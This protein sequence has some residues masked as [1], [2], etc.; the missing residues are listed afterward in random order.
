[1]TQARIRLTYDYDQAKFLLGIKIKHGQPIFALEPT[2]RVVRFELECTAKGDTDTVIVN[3]LEDGSYSFSRSQKVLG[4]VNLHYPTCFWDAQITVKALKLPEYDSLLQDVSEIAKTFQVNPVTENQVMV[5]VQKSTAR[6]QVNTVKIIRETFHPT[7]AYPG[8]DLKLR[9]TRIVRCTES[10]YISD[11]IGATKNL[12]AQRRVWWTAH[13]ISREANLALAR[14]QC[15]ELGEEASWT[16]VAVAKD[17][18]VAE[19]M[20]VAD[21]LLP[22]ID[23]VGWCE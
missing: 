4:A 23:G 15:S 14:G 2:L 8:L 11:D 9:E 10:P 22:R 1:M 19:L 20:A 5:S 13:I 16:A 17:E 7:A 18:T 6:L 12:G 3:I 21:L